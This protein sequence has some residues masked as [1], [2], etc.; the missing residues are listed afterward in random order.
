MKRPDMKR[1][2]GVASLLTVALLAGC[3]RESATTPEGPTLLANP[4]Q[5]PAPISESA[6]PVV[7]DRGLDLA[8][9]AAIAPA[10]TVPTS[11]HLTTWPYKTV[12][13][14]HETK[15]TLYRDENNKRWLHLVTWPF[16]TSYIP[17]PDPLPT[18]DHLP[19]DVSGAA[20]LPVN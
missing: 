9:L 7:D 11:V 1:T 8:L 4:D 13:L 2:A 14:K 5:L 6:P 17:Y 20:G 19:V 18:A 10:D 15:T 12:N 3:G 16:E